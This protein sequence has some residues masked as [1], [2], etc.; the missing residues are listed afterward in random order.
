MYAKYFKRIFDFSLSLIALIILSPVFLILTIIGTVAVKGNPF[1]TQLRPGK[2]DKKSGKEKIF[3]LVKFRTMSNKKSHNQSLQ[4]KWMW[5]GQQYI[6]CHFL[7][8]C[9]RYNTTQE[10]RPKCQSYD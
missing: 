1:F 3:K 10:R 6:L 7:Y 5:Q 2:I 8:F 9:T 4:A